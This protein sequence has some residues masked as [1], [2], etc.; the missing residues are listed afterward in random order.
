VVKLTV[1][2]DLATENGIEKVVEMN[3]LA[4]E[5]KLIGRIG[6]CTV[7]PRFEQSYR[8]PVEHRLASG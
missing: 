2:A 8:R 5:A 3:V 6:L 7:A 1:A 4:V